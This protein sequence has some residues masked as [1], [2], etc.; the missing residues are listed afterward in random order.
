MVQYGDIVLRDGGAGGGEAAFPMTV[1]SARCES[2][3]LAYQRNIL[4][5]VARTFALTIAPLPGTLY[6]AAGNLYLLCRIADTIEDEPTLS[7]EQKAAFSERFVQLVV[8]TGDPAAFGS[9]LGALLSSATT[10]S[11]RDLVAN[12]ARVLRVTAQLNPAQRSAIERCVRIMTR[13]MVEFQQAASPG[14]LRD[15]AHLDRY[16]Y[17]VAGVVGETLTAFFCDYSAEIA[18]RRDDLLALSVSFGKGLQMINVL[19]DIWEDHRRGACWLPRDVFRTAGVELRSLSPGQ[20]DPGFVAGLLELVAITRRH[21]A[22]ALR[23]ILIIPARETGIR[24]SCLWPLGIAVL[25]LRRIRRTPAF[26]SGDE[27][28]VSRRSV[29]AVVVVSNIFA[30]SNLALKLLFRLLTRGLPRAAGV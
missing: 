24:R 8:G 5:G 26:A 12:T 13:G 4:E 28:K 7:P 11:E 9:E 16:C 27:V 1:D 2:D 19:K 25:T 23:Y 3:D 18:K 29:G 6:D 21:L 10:E 22:N 17:H 30:R 14:G 15:M 20:A